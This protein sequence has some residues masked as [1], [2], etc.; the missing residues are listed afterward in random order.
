VADLI[1]RIKF[2]TKF[3][4]HLPPWLLQSVTTSSNIPLYTPTFLC[5]HVLTFPVPRILIQTTFQTCHLHSYQPLL[6]Y[7]IIPPTL[8]AWT[9]VQPT[10]IKHHFLKMKF[11]SRLSPFCSRNG[12]LPHHFSHDTQLVCHVFK[13]WAARFLLFW[14]SIVLQAI[15][16]H[17]LF[18]SKQFFRH[19]CRPFLSYIKW[20][21]IVDPSIYSELSTL[22]FC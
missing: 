14:H 17:F 21:L 6:V 7:S 9:T 16:I 12:H 2:R 1:Y 20:N 22:F 8:S 11:S 5:M 4:V 18:S 3:K 10:Y 15:Q 19:G 13:H